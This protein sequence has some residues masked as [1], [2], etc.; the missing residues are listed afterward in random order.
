MEVD[1]DLV[2]DVEYEIEENIPLCRHFPIKLLKVNHRG[3]DLMPSIHVGHVLTL[4]RRIYNRLVDDGT[5]E[6]EANKAGA[7]AVSVGD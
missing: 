3:Q 7:I 4:Q 2:V 1:L 5:I 6:I